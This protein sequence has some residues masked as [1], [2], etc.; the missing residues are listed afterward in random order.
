MILELDQPILEELTLGN[1]CGPP[2]QFFLE[3]V[4]C[5]FF[6]PIEINFTA[7]GF[8]LYIW[9]KCIILSA[10]GQNCFGKSCTFGLP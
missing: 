6:R 3:K 9:S 8:K 2:L 10:F 1:P 7:I 4:F 5:N